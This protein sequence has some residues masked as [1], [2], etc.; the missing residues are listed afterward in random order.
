M[1]KLKNGIFISY[2]HKDKKWVDQLMIHL[3]P[4]IRNEQ[5][6]LR[7]WNDTQIQPGTRWRDEI[8]NAIDK[9]RIALLLVSPNFLASDYIMENELPRILKDAYKRDTIIYWIAV[10]YSSYK[11]TELKEFQAINDPTKPLDSLSPSDRNQEL[12]EIA[13]KIA[14]GIELNVIS[15]FLH[16]I[17][18]FVPQQKAFLDKVPID[19]RDRKFSIQAHQNGDQI[20]LTSGEQMVETIRADDFDKLDR[21]SKQLIRSYERTMDELFDRWT[22]LLPKSRSR[23]EFLK[24]EAR[25]EMSIIRVDLC[26]LLNAVLDFLSS[27]GKNLQDHYYHVRHLCAKD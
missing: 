25:S 11:F 7:V 20:H 10:S 27:M 22:E 23:D 26:E 16:V 2:S 14:N 3:K 9:S 17:D 19:D 24:E 15:N 6:H 4:L 1:S 5:I 8:T 13:N 18:E 21:K 12:V